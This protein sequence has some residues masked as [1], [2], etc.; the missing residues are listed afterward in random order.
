MIRYQER[1]AR[2][3]QGMRRRGGIWG[4]VAYT[5]AN[6]NSSFVC[7]RACWGHQA[8]IKH[9]VLG[10]KENEPGGCPSP[11]QRQNCE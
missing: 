9:F 4:L 2:P 6:S 1:R 5:G 11:P 7:F 3:K 8:M 10:S